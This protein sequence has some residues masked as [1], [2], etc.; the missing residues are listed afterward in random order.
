MTIPWSWNDKSPIKPA[1]NNIIHCTGRIAREKAAATTRPV[2]PLIYAVAAYSVHVRSVR[3]ITTTIF[4]I[5]DNVYAG[6]NV[7]ILF[8]VIIGT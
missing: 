4:T 6:I 7:G 5:I 2:I 8:N 3:H 1:G